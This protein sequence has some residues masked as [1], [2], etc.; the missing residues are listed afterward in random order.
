MKPQRRKSKGKEA[1]PQ[2]QRPWQAIRPEKVAR[3]RELAADPD[4]PSAEVMTKVAQLLARHLEPPR[5]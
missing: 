4:Y 3:G 1:V 2:G 5:G